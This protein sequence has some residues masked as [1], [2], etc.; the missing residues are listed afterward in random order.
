[1][2]RR[3]AISL[4]GFFFGLWLVSL[5]V[6]GQVFPDRSASQFIT[7]CLQRE[8]LLPSERHTVEQLLAVVE[9][10]YCQVANDSLSA[11]RSLDLHSRQITSLRPLIGFPQLEQLYL[12]DNQIVDVG[13]LS[14][15]EK[16]TTLN[17]DNNQIQDLSPLADLRALSVLFAN[18]NRIVSLTPLANLT[19]L[20]QLIVNDN[21]IEEIGALQA[22]AHLTTLH[23]GNNRL[24][25]VTPLATVINLQELSLRNNQ[26]THLDPLHS[27][28]HLISLDSRNNSLIRKSCPVFPAT[29]CLFSDDAAALNRIA[30]QQQ[31]QENFAAAI[32]TTQMA[33]EVYQQNGDSLRESSTLDRIGNLYDELGQYANS[34][35]YYQ[36]AAAIRQQVGDRQGEGDTLTNLG[37]TYVRLGQTDKA[38]ASLKDALA[39]QTQLTAVDRA[40]PKEGRILS[41]LALAY[42]RLSQPDNALRYGKLSLAK[43]RSRVHPDRLGEAI[44]LNRIGAAYLKQGNL[45]KAQLYLEKA[46]DF[47]RQ[48][49]NEP[50]R[51]RSLHNLGNL[52]LRQDN[53]AKALSRY[54]QAQTLWQSLGD[55]ASEGDTLNA[56]GDLYL[57]T[58]QID[59]AVAVFRQT[60]D[61]W[62]DLGLGLTDENKISLADIQAHTYRTL[63]QALIAKANPEAALEVSESGRARAFAELLAH[64]LKIQGKPV[65]PAQLK[66]PSIQEIREI[67]HA[68]QATLVEYS[69]MPTELYI[70]VIEPTGTVHF[71]HQPLAIGSIGSRVNRYRR[72]LGLRGRGFSATSFEGDVDLSARRRVEQKQ[73]YQ[74]L[75]QPIADL[76]PPASPIII[77]PQG[78]L[79]MVAFPALQ[80]ATGIDFIEKHP[81]L[82]APAIGLLKDSSRFTQPS[83]RLGQS[84]ALV[85]GNPDMPNDPD[86]KKPLTPLQGTKI[87]AEKIAEILQTTPL[88]G[89]AATKAAVVSQIDKVDIVH[90]ATH[91]LLDDFGTAFPGAL[92]LTP[93]EQDEGF[94]KATDILELSLTAR[95]AVLSACDTG[96]GKI[97]GDG[98]VGL[99][100][101]F[102][103]AGVDSVIVSL[104]DV[105]DEETA[106]LMIRFYAQLTEESNRAIALQ[107]AMLAMRELSP[108]SPE[109]W[110]AFALFGAM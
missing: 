83:L 30:A 80:D 29:I 63:Q 42:D 94:L 48:Q 108:N 71:R 45:K 61:I 27:L 41:S 102:L 110:A 3:I 32:A 13:P 99:S 81:L 57:A 15:L 103:T 26:I 7:L 95:L 101:S 74:L 31:Q 8:Q 77:I 62:Q 82:F 78:N 20:T 67:A 91:G 47:S 54:K 10:S 4:L 6:Q 51:A 59:Q 43:Y 105:P 85:V 12:N 58:N 19:E 106:G 79:F 65:S 60:I 35:N 75:I 66:S 49:K 52:A 100:R 23:L 98:V 46:L 1:M 109:K 70:W 24:R 68:Q 17:L 92:A 107:K 53:P 50:S 11:L 90:L 104:W 86:T 76:L 33:L 18:S 84:S 93:T 87:E 44:A 34:L 36:Q 25:D 96:R 2:S 16:L 37:I 38:R 28:S 9:T 39:I 22:H 73:L 56:I 88:I 40:E 14:Q 5:P 55:V 89:S 21:Q 64:R 69:L 72:A 97:T